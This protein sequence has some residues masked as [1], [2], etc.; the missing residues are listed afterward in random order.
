M[1]DRQSDRPRGRPSNRPY[2]RS[3]SRSG[4]RS[5]TRMSDSESYK[6]RG[7]AQSQRG[8]EERDESSRGDQDAPFDPRSQASRSEYRPR[9]DSSR[10]PYERSGGSYAGEG[11][12]NS[13]KLK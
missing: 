10:P 5:S 9:D 11:E 12:R 7:G 3:R 13:T 6:S 1:A 2:S 8:R 4:D